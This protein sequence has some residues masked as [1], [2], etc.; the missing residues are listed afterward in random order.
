MLQYSVNV[1]KQLEKVE[2]SI[3]RN[4]EQQDLVFSSLLAELPASSTTIVTN[5]TVHTTTFNKTKFQDQGTMSL[6]LRRLRPVS[7]V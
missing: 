6:P 4:R 7:E 1:R 2:S 5:H 3:K